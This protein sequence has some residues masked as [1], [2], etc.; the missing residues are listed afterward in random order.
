[1]DEATV[2]ERCERHFDYASTDPDTAHEMY[3]DHADL[4]FPQSGE[5][6]VGDQGPLELRGQHPRVSR[7]QDRAWVDLRHGGLGATRVAGEMEIRT[8]AWLL[9]ASPATAPGR[10]RPDKIR[11][12]KRKDSMSV[13]TIL[14][15]II[16]VLLV[17]YL[18]RRVF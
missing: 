6:F 5:R 4:E 12:L 7:G 18:V 16:L 13:V 15:V 9:L 14:I 17:I 3:Q 11:R 2:R 10:G 1:V 8:M